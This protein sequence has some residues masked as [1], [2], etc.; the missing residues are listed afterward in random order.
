MSPLAGLSTEQLD[1]LSRALAAVAIAVPEQQAAPPSVEPAVPAAA[2]SRESLFEPMARALAQKHP[3][4]LEASA[5]ANTLVLVVRGRAL[6]DSADAEADALLREH[7]LP[8]LCPAADA[9]ADAPVALPGDAVRLVVDLRALAA[10]PR[11][12]AVALLER[13]GA[14][15]ASR[16]FGG[17]IAVVLPCADDCAAELRAAAADTHLAEAFAP[18]RC[19][20]FTRSRDVAAFM[21]SP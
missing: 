2:P 8:L 12:A 14:F 20:V 21:D 11:G 16:C 13:W 6:P 1:G 5:K 4:R 17:R 7:A 15:V 18:L 10:F 3:L 9:P 19:A